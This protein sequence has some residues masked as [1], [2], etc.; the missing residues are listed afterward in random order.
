MSTRTLDQKSK[1]HTASGTGD[2]PQHA[3]CTVNE[4]KFEALTVTHGMKYLFQ[5]PLQNY[6][7][8]HLNVVNDMQVFKPPLKRFLFSNSFY[9][10]ERY[11]NFDK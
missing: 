1:A 11:F 3:G 5:V 7:N 8:G 10:V 6:F 4:R 9:S 2:T